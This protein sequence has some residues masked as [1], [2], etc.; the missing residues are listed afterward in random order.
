MFEC[1]HRKHAFQ[2]HPGEGKTWKKHA[3]DCGKEFSRTLFAAADPNYGPDQYAL[4]VLALIAL[5]QMGPLGP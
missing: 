5:R 3:F 1:H 4:P 2:G